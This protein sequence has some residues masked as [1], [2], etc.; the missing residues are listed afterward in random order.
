[1]DYIY[2]IV[3]N[4]HSNYYDFYEWKK[5]DKIINVNKIPIY[6]IS[7]KDY[8]NL[9]NNCVTIE[10]STLSKE[11]KMFLV[12][13][14]IEVMGLLIDNS[15]KILKRSSLIFEESDDILE[16]KESI[17]FIDI[18]YQINKSKNVNYESRVN[19]EK[20]KY[21]ESYL[22]RIDLNKDEYLL[23]Y[24][25][26][27]IYN[28]EEENINKIYKKLIELKDKDLNKIYEGIKRIKLELNI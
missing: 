25:Y 12:T 22:K 7:S 28:Q 11:S 24:L 14:G 10:K 1:M 27:D 26:Y 6:K 17:K 2:D 20:R 5:D 23:K 4:F 8:L 3:L 9:K 15:G 13:N 18:K 16:D 19:K 21:I